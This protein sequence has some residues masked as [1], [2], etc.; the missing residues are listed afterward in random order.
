MEAHYPHVTD[1]IALVR[2][3]QWTPEY[4]LERGRLV[5]RATALLDGWG[6]GSGLDYDSLHPVL[7]PYVDAWGSFMALTKPKFKAIETPVVH[8]AYRYQG[9]LDRV[10]DEEVWDI[11]CGPDKHPSTGFQLSAYER[12]YFKGLRARPRRRLAIHLLPT[13]RYFVEEYK[14]R[15]DFPLFLGLLNIH[16]WR[17]A[18]GLYRESRD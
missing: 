3:M 10:T 17:T 16:Q 12:G 14:D 4:A 5:H 2:N 1:V 9:R 7:K 13:G 15:A 18:H 8:Q 6:D 11:K